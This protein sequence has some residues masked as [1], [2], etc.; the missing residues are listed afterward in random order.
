MCL[1][2]FEGYFK[3]IYYQFGSLRELKNVTIRLFTVYIKRKK[4]KQL[5]YVFIARRKPSG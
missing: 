1:E 3:L 2:S 5:G 4:N